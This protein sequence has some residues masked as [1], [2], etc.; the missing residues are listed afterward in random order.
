MHVAG[1]SLW[2]DRSF[3]DDSIL[4]AGIFNIRVLDDLER[5]L[6]CTYENK[7]ATTSVILVDPSVAN[8][9]RWSNWLVK[10]PDLFSAEKMALHLSDS[11]STSF[12]FQFNGSEFLGIYDTSHVESSHLRNSVPHFRWRVLPERRIEGSMNGQAYV[13]YSQ[14]QWHLIDLQHVFEKIWRFAHSLK[15]ANAR[16]IRE[17]CVHQS[18]KR[19]GC[20][21]LIADDPEEIVRE[22][23]VQK[24]EI[25]AFQNR[26][27]G[28]LG[29]QPAEPRS[30]PRFSEI[31]MKSVLLEQFRGKCVGEIPLAVLSSL[32]RMDGAV[33][34]TKEGDLLG[35]GIILRPRVRKG[36]TVDPG[37]RT[38]TARATSFYGLTIKISDDGPIT[39]FRNASQIA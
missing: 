33:V 32:A 26:I 27:T 9:L 24:N 35:F 3:W 30:H 37:A 7:P 13:S 36:V 11:D 31:P 23:V 8:A 4:P 14:G 1:R 17:L 16:R 22:G 15:E 10:A 2:R 18:N 5:M 28:A 19:E 20:L 34:I 29:E 39:A 38:A 21:I 6:S 25:N 12:V